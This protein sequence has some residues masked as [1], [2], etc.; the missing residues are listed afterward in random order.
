MTIQFFNEYDVHFD[1][2][3]L[4]DII[5]NSILE[6]KAS[7]ALLFEEIRLIWVTDEA[8]KKMHIDFLNDPSYTDVMTFPYD[9]DA[10]LYISVDRAKIVSKNLSHSFT[11]ELHYYAV[12]GVLHLCNYNDHDEEDIVKMRAAEKRYLAFLK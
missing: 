7:E 1:D 12:H 4:S 6:I 9:D 2:S 8:L 5:R 3:K 11:D 10:E